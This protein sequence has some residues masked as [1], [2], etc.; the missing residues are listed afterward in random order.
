LAL[1]AFR[2]STFDG[3]FDASKGGM[4]RLRVFGQ[5]I[6]GERVAAI[7]RAG[8]TLGW[9]SLFCLSSVSGM[10]FFLPVAIPQEQAAGEGSCATRVFRREKWAVLYDLRRDIVLFLC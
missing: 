1:Q 4:G 8:R 10:G 9:V 6:Y 2:V 7:G 5:R 3:S